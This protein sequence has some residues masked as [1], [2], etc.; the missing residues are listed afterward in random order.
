[1][2]TLTEKKFLPQQD[3]HFTLSQSADHERLLHIEP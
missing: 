3:E 1:M 2:N